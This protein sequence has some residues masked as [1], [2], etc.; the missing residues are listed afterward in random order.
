MIKK[1]KVIG[2]S[3]ILSVVL[4]F[5]SVPV[6]AVTN[7]YKKYDTDSYQS[8]VKPDDGFFGFINNTVSD[9]M[10]SIANFLFGINK[11]IWQGFDTVINYAYKADI[12]NDYANMIGNVSKTMYHNLFSSV[13][14]LFLAIVVA[15]CGIAFIKGSPEKAFKQLLTTFV[16]II[17]AGVWFNQSGYFMKVI[18]GVT[19][20]LQSDISSAGTIS[21]NRLVNNGQKDSISSASQN[22]R[23]SYFQMSVEEP[24]YLMNYGTTDT[25]AIKNRTHD[26][27]SID[28]FLATKVTKDSADKVKQ[29]LEAVDYD[30]NNYL[31]PDQL[32]YKMTVSSFAILETL[33]FGLIQTVIAI[34]SIVI[35]FLAVLID[36]ILP[37][38]AILS[39][40]P[41][42]NNLFYGGVKGMAMVL[43]AKASLGIVMLSFRLI[44]LFV[45]GLIPRSSVEGYVGNGMFKGLMILVIYFFRRPL[46]SL[47][48]TMVGA[49]LT[50]FRSE[51]VPEPINNA[52]PKTAL[53]KNADKETKAELD[54]AVFD[55]LNKNLNGLTDAIQG[56]PDWNKEEVP[57]DEKNN[58]EVED[59]QVPPE[60]EESLNEALPDGEIEDANSDVQLENPDAVKAEMLEDEDISEV[61]KSKIV[62]L[63]EYQNLTASNYEGNGFNSLEDTQPPEIYDRSSFEERL[64]ELEMG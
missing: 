19:N 31:S 53:E 52:I 48:K 60:D 17:L 3:I 18:N 6:L 39:I 57:A 45:D 10:N 12:F 8:F 36:L 28:E 15:T 43:L 41:R 40:F 27:K 16:V 42:F 38:F 56:N 26:G 59:T 23:S 4:F 50:K 25:N 58:E 9:M 29:N 35:Q 54:P 11:M 33:V 30:K 34:L 47:M 14:L 13:G 20:E 7:Q 37:V 2:F 63:E 21:G 24:Y 5:Q 32:P 61:D 62:N 46:A 64:A 1:V 44:L 22:L 55:S 49:G 51:A